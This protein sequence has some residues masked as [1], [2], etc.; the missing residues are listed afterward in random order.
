M[1]VIHTVKHN[2][3]RIVWGIW[4]QKDLKLTY[5]LI[6]MSLKVP[7]A[8]LVTHVLVKW[9]AGEGSE[10][11]RSAQKKKELQDTLLRMYFNI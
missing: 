4:V 10:I 1:N 8:V 11:M 5:K 9:L 6:S 3:K 7:M 2:Q